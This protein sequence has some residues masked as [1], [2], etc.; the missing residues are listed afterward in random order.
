M[1]ASISKPM[2][3]KAL[4]TY[5]SKDNYYSQGDGLENSQWQ[6]KFSEH[7]GLT[8][9]ITAEQWQQACNGKDNQGQALRR[10]QKNS[11]AGWDITLSANKSAS[12]KALVDQDPRVLEAHRQAVT[13][14]VNYIEEHCIFAQVKQQGQVIS[15]QTKQGQ[16][17]LFKHDD[18]RNQEPQL[19]THVVILNQTLCVDG[20]SRTLDSRE[21]FNQKKT[22]GAYYDHSFAH[23]LHK[24]GFEIDWTGEHTFE[25]RGYEPE[26][27]E[28][29][30]SRRQ[31]IRAY[32][33]QQN[34]QLE[35]ATEHQKQIACLESR[36]AKVH[37]L[38]PADHE[39]QRESWKRISAELNI[40]HPQPQQDLERAYTRDSHPGSIQTVIEAAIESATAHQV[41]VSRPRLLQDC[42]RH[43]QAFYSPVEIEQALEQSE[44]L[45]S[46]DDGRL[47]TNR[48]IQREQLILEVANNGQES[49]E[50]LVT[51]EQVN[52]IA[53]EKGLNEGQAAG[54]L[55]MATSTDQITLLQGNAGVGKTYTL[56]AFRDVLDENAQQRLRGLAPSAA[57]SEVLGQEAGM[58]SSTVDRYLLIPNKQLQRD[59]ILVIDE[60][61]MLSTQQMAK[62]I[63]K[64]NDL[65]SRLI[66]V[67]DTKQLSAVQA[68]AP[69]RLLQERSQLKTVTIDENL[70]QV[71]P[72]LKEAVDLA[73][74]Q[75]SQAALEILDGHGCVK[76]IPVLK[77]RNHSVAKRYLSRPHERQVQT[78]IICDTN[79][80]RQD[81]T[82]QIRAAYIDRQTLGTE[83]QVIEMLHP[84]N[85][86]K[87][88]I[89]QAYS[90]EVGDV[91]RF[92][93]ST[94]Q[95]PEPYYRVVDV[96]P[97]RLKL[98]DRFGEVKDCPIDKYKDREVFSAQEIE[99][100]VGDR[101]RFTRNHR[102]WGQIN[103]QLF[104]IDSFN[105]DGTISINTKGK[106]ERLTPDQLVHVDYAYCRTVYAAQGW[107]AQEAIWAPGKSPGKE[108]TYV[109]LSRAKSE[110]EIV[111]TDRTGLGLSAQFSRGQENAQDLIEVPVRRR[112]TELLKLQQEVKAW[113]AQDRPEQPDLAVGERLKQ[114]VSQLSVQRSD[115]VFDCREQQQE[116][117]EMGPQRSLF[118]W[119][120]E[121][122][123]VIEAKRQLLHES[124]QQLSQ[125]ERTLRKAQ[126][127][128]QGWQGQMDAYQKWDEDPQTELMR[129]KARQLQESQVQSRLQD[130]T[131]AYELHTNVLTILKQ[132]G[133][134]EGSAYV[135]RGERYLLRLDGTELRVWQNEI[136]EPI[137]EMLDLRSAG[138]YLEVRQM[139]VT[140]DGYQDIATAAQ[141]FEYRYQ[142]KQSIDHYG[143][144]FSR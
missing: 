8:G 86:D 28:S 13:A 118:N 50:A 79:Q 98:Q 88:A 25:I 48:A 114:R 131:M 26:Q 31:D 101:L 20:K 15:E 40:I 100:R 135:Y 97:N 55:H 142:V 110:L 83:A 43:A 140:K 117:E 39:L 16:F 6:G 128:L 136:E 139:K 112:D 68:G 94:K 66:L 2:N 64:A 9:R 141:S 138:G 32:L 111:T 144:S 14:T 69:F 61:G 60:A 95:F 18:N 84:K 21:L 102:E 3:A 105:P 92:R 130:L 17:A 125:V 67:G 52:A 57:T 116:L 124:Q 127:Q 108:Q 82:H 85:L 133:S 54:L 47:T 65:S 7:Q 5:H 90:Y 132:A 27:L 22:I 42:L 77:A 44:E 23:Q 30:S 81:I 115:L 76:E 4:E 62:L 122:P 93:R 121:R 72:Q 143:P 38:T 46:T 51:P 87:N 137:L 58:Q 53:Q 1:V 91:V 119:S 29:F 120:G 74:E 19:H 33:E 123:E 99:L 107:T 34:I 106:I 71:T 11:R 96:Q 80:D 49:R 37:K 89:A 63:E 45:I 24:Q 113:L 109:A 104:T 134:Q 56:S 35:Q 70:R 12:L 36:T 73:A 41:A 78:L 126:R 59:E 75:Q 129:E 103:G 10:Q